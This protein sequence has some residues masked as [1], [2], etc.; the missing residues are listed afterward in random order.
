[1]FSFISILIVS[2]WRA[3]F[4]L[5]ERWINQYSMAENILNLSASWPGYGLQ[6]IY[7]CHRLL[8][9]SWWPGQPAIL[10]LYFADMRFLKKFN[11]IY[12]SAGALCHGSRR[13]R[14]LFEMY[15]LC[16]WRATRQKQ[17]VL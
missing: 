3:K 10:E 16:S 5:R 8:Y 6:M 17:L 9:L 15:M 4:M 12:M 7:F 13:I 1:M 14:T 2:R 11:H